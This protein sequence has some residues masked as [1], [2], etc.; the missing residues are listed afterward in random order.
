MALLVFVAVEGFVIPVL[1]SPNLGLSVHRLGALQGELLL[2]LG[3]VWPRL[4][5]GAG[6]SRIAYWTYLYS[7]FATLTAYVLAALWGAGNTVMTLAAG[8]ARGSAVQETIMI[9]RMVLYSA[10]LTFLVSMAF[11]IRGLRMGNSREP[12]EQERGDR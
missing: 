2:G 7:S 5:L 12:T 11:V 10:A 8:T 4:K 3:L 9:I 1:A 6:A